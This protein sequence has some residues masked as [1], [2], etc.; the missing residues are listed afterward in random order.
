MSQMLVISHDLQLLRDDMSLAFPR[1]QFASRL[2]V[3][4]PLS[5]CHQ[6]VSSNLDIKNVSNEI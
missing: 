6:H 5:P 2:K 3:P 4:L 1:A